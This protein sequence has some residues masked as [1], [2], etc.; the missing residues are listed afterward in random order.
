DERA[1]EE[2]DAA[3]IFAAAGEIVPA[4]LGALARGGVLVCAG[5]HMSTIPAFAY[6]LLW[7]ERVVR[8]VA[9]L[10][11]A[12]A[13]RFLAL[14]REVPIHT[15]VHRYELAET[16]RALADLRAGRFDGAAVVEVGR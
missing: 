8:S 2:L 1:P 6:D 10:R 16:G 15:E 5:I 12:D 11:R 3:I 4:A 14:A 13:V 7:G 9:N